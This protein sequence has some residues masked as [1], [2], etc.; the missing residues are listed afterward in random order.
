MVVAWAGNQTWTWVIVT[1][2]VLA[3]KAW[4]G[5][6]EHLRLGCE[7]PGEANGQGAARVAVD[8]PGRKDPTE[9]WAWHHKE[10]PGE[11]I[12]ESPG[13]SHQGIPIFWRCKYHGMAA[14]N[15]SLRGVELARTP[16]TDCAS[17]RGQNWKSDP[18]PLGEPRKSWVNPRHGTLSYIHIW[19]CFVKI[20]TVPVL[21]SW[22]MKNV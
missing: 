4:G 20:V 7:S 22:Y 19:L 10:S 6:R 16:K 2:V 8:F 18:G 13:Q 3:L 5:H 11:A 15:G 17:C 14:K 12:G 1:Q 9:S 21:L